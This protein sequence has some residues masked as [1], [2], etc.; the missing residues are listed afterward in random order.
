ML[1]TAPRR[2]A[3]M[4]DSPAAEFVHVT[5]DYTRGVLGLSKRRAV[6]DVSLTVPAGT[7]YGL[8][9]PNRAGKTTLVKLL[10]SLCRATTGTVRRLG[11]S[12]A[13]RRTLGR[14]GYVHGN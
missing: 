11:E 8:V 5:K 12:V 6:S 10:L 14:V 13:R 9:G 7:V 1:T 3:P 4:P 2:L